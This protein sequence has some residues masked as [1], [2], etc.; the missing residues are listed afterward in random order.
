MCVSAYLV[1]GLFEPLLPAFVGII[2]MIEK[3]GIW[4]HKRDRISTA[5]YRKMLIA[6]EVTWEFKD[7]HMKEKR[8]KSL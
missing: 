2:L 7:F 5:F 6:E 4:L 8:H 1:C 3:K